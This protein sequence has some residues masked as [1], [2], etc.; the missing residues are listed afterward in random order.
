ME[1]ASGVLSSENQG[2]R[3]KVMLTLQK[4]RSRMIEGTTALGE[5]KVALEVVDPKGTAAAA[6]ALGVRDGKSSD[7]EDAKSSSPPALK[8][9]ELELVVD[10][11]RAALLLAASLGRDMYELMIEL[12]SLARFCCGRAM[13]AK[14]T[15]PSSA[16]KLDYLKCQLMVREFETCVAV[17][18]T[19]LLS[20]AVKKESG[21]K[22]AQYSMTLYA[23]GGGGG[24]R[25]SSR[26]GMEGS[27]PKTKRSATEHLADFA[28]NLASEPLLD[29]LPTKRLDA[30]RLKQHVE[31]L[32]VLERALMAC[33]RLTEN[34]EQEAKETGVSDRF[35][36]GAVPLAT[37]GCILVWNIAKPL[38]QTHLR[39]HVHRALG[40]SAQFLATVGSPLQ[41]L[42]VMLHYELARC[43]IATDFLAK[44]AEHFAAARLCDYGYI[45]KTEAMPQP[46]SDGLMQD[47]VKELGNAKL[48]LEEE[49]KGVNEAM[50]TVA[51]V[52]SDEVEDLNGEGK[53][54]GTGNKVAVD[55][56]ENERRRY[57]DRAILPA[58]DKL[59]LKK[60]IYEEPEKSE[61][62]ALL[63]IE[64]AKEVT[65]A[66]LQQTLLAQA[67]SLLQEAS[68]ESFI[69]NNMSTLD[70]KNAP[71]SDVDAILKYADAS[72]D[73]RPRA[74]QQSASTNSVSLKVTTFYHAVIGL[75]FLL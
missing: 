51:D 4:V 58:E 38:L 13:N 30:L 33:E 11:G 75:L 29:K 9:S 17:S 63:L 23:T 2:V 66:Q 50:Q 52:R 20:G 39:K 43:E 67:A 71:Q 57:L 40:L 68:E 42:R 35:D 27:A 41:K 44:A 1:T 5:L 8:A 46:R 7:L 32:K 56:D 21:T 70:R 37:E 49:G 45:D 19:E 47:L 73:G 16:V 25:G 53:V 59:N 72:A 15:Q 60:S 10:I 61:E 48:H 3:G 54:S 24:S 69:A 14:D 12:D 26:D 64:Q 34:I 18:S 28:A 22:L 74:L 62:K 36:P 31:A 65:S 6:A 55:M